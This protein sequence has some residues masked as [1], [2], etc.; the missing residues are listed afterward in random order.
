[1]KI[2]ILITG[3][4]IDKS[5]DPMSGNMIL[6]DTHIPTMLDE[7]LCELDVQA[8]QVMQK[9]SLD[10]TYYDHTFIKEECE[11][12]EHDRIV[13]THGTDTMVRT[14]R[15][16]GA[17]GL[18]KTIVLTGAFV[19][20]WIKGADASFN[21]GSAITAAQILPVGVYIAMNG[22]IYNWDNVVKDVEEGIFKELS[23][24]QIK[25]DG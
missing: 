3:G 7:G 24:E 12:C 4:T 16:I 6:A 20:Y 15:E 10:M 25:S 8:T 21:L 11:K 1:M 17:A 5:Y 13:I 22:K 18:E 23:D 14:A 19:P 9:D 2:A